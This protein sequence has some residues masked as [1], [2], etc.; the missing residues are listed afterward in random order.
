MLLVLHPDTRSGKAAG[1]GQ[2]AS[3]AQVFVSSRHK[4]IMATLACRLA[5]GTQ[6]GRLDDQRA[7]S[8]FSCPCGPIKPYGSL[9]HQEPC[10][11]FSR[12]CFATQTARIKFLRIRHAE[13]PKSHL[14]IRK[15]ASYSSL[16]ALVIYALR[17]Y[18]GHVPIYFAVL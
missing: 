12:G 2:V 17:I 15:C 18:T 13:K 9:L 5:G 1:T 8:Q 6:A 10:P 4:E 7:L 11:R 14:E 16:R 3:S